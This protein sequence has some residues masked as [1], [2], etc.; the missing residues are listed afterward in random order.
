ML[1]PLPVSLTALQADTA[2]LA[3]WRRGD[4]TIDALHS[5]RAR[6]VERR[7]IQR[8][9]G[10]VRE[11]LVTEKHQALPSSLTAAAAVDQP[12]P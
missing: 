5:V 9:H 2:L 8:S 12:H 10:A 11:A 3:C 4:W 1:R 7:V 6:Q